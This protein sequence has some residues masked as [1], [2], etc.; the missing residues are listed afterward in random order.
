MRKAFIK[1]LCQ[2]AKENKKIFLITGD[3]GFNIL[4]PFQESYPD[5][6]L[7]IG[8]AE[9]NLVTVAAGL[10]TTGFIPFIYSIATFATMR[11]YE[12][13]RNNISLQNLNVKII[14]I[15]AGFAYTKAGP[16]HHSMEDISLMR[17]LPNFSVIAPTD[18]LETFYAT[19]NISNFKGPVYMRLERNPD[20]SDFL[21]SPK[22]FKIGKAKEIYAGTEIA[23]LTTGTKLYTGLKV[24]SLLKEKKYNPG[25]FSFSTIKPLDEK[26]LKKIA[27][28][29][30]LLITIEEQ[31]KDG[32]FGSIVSEHI[33]SQNNHPFLLRFGFK[34]SYINQSWDYSSLLAKN[35]LLPEQILR[36]ILKFIKTVKM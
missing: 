32:G 22:I 31:Y 4:E 29:Y 30:S 1:A 2:I 26:L 17:L 11:P 27:A 25:L 36:K 18:P 12:Q 14:G 16:T 5:R 21:L 10:A 8:V 13:I 6:F 33:A 24:Q 34:N 7:N 23:I 3:L 35:D 9:A 20:V 15:G 28:K 19:T